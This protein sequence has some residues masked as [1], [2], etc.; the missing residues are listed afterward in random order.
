M[1]KH[2]K[3]GASFFQ[4]TTSQISLLSLAGAPLLFLPVAGSAT[5]SCSAIVSGI[6][7]ATA[8]T[9][10]GDIC[11]LA[12]LEDAS[13]TLPSWVTKLS[14]LAVGGGGGAST[15]NGTSYSGGGGQVTILDNTPLSNRSL[16]ITVGESGASSSEVSEDG[17]SS[18]IAAAGAEL[19]LARGG[20]A[21]FKGLTGD[22]GKSYAYSLDGGATATD[23][24]SRD[25]YLSYW[26]GAGTAGDA[27]SPYGGDGIN[28]DALSESLDQTLWATD[29][30]LPGTTDNLLTFDFGA[31]G[32]SFDNEMNAV[33]GSGWGGSI[34]IAG[35]SNTARTAGSGLVV[36]RFAIGAEEEQPAPV[37]APYNGPL[38]ISLERPLVPAGGPNE[39]VLVGR[40]L[41]NVTTAEVDG[42]P[43]EILSTSSDRIE[44]IIPALGPGVYTI[45]YYS[46]SGNIWHQDSLTVRAVEITD[47]VDQTTG[48]ETVPASGEIFRDAKRF[49]NY[50]GDRGGIVSAD[51][52]AIRAF[53]GQYEN[54]TRITCIGSTSG[55]PAVP[56]DEALATARAENACRIAREMFP[57]AAVSLKTNTGSG[58]G[59]FYRAVSI[60]LVGTK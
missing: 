30:T 10:S 6:S 50:A 12:F 21:G 27:S 41:E 39:N 2:A 34:D 22:D 15:N 13:I 4:R 26:A 8:T 11:E 32:T 3:T 25:D 49:F 60:Y 40:R 18:T 55:V 24:N 52:E 20:F 9:L 17:S 16:V 51:D 53:L 28:L 31:G 29:S 43:I 54:V 47:P 1:A 48:S 36:L 5:D 57:D 42:K 46:P 7:G 37:P 59:Q 33:A 56:S 58:V 23:K 35:G 38:P 19:V 44:M 14:A 45:R